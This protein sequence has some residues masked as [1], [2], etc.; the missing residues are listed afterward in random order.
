M[1][2]PNGKKMLVQSAKIK[3]R[4]N[5]IR[6]ESDQASFTDCFT[7]LFHKAVNPDPRTQKEI[8]KYTQFNNVIII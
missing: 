6:M 7:A 1:V 3:E 2:E 8:E 4:Q 5:P